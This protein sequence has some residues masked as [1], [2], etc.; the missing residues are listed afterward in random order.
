M[1][2]KIKEPVNT[3]THFATCILAVFGTIYL[4]LNSIGELS[5][6]VTLSIYGISLISLY[7]ASALYHGTKTTKEKEIILKKIDHV[8]IFFLIAGS[9]TPVFS[10]GLPPVWRTVM[11]TL[12]WV[13]AIVGM[14]LKVFYVN[15]PRWVSSVVYVSLGWIALVPLYHLIKAFPM[16]AIVLMILGG[17]AY[18]FGAVIYAT[19]WFDF[20]PGKFGFHENFHIWTMIGSIVHFV[21]IAMYI[22]PR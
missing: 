2:I 11:L 14:V 10:F 1:K 12:I 4:I 22:L 18:T 3:L 8:A 7:G 5:K 15:V 16:P 6:V 21:F 9:Y 17:V 19:K 20:V 13:L